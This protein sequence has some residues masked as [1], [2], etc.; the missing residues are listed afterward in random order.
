MLLFL[1]FLPKFSKLSMGVFFMDLKQLRYFFTIA[2]EGQITRAAKVLH[3]AQPPLSQSLKN[4]EEELGV[5]LFERSGRK[6][7]LTDAGK[8][9][10]KHIEGLFD[11]LD[12]ILQEVQETEK[13]IRGKLAIGSTKTLFSYLP[14]RMKRFKELYPDITFELREG[15][16]YFLSE[17]LKSRAI[18][19]ALVRLPLNLEGFTYKMLPKEKYMAAFPGSWAEKINQSS[20]SIFELATYPLMLLHRISGVGQ[21]EVILGGFERRGLKPN[22]ICECPDVDMLLGLVAEEV[23]VTIIPEKTLLKFGNNKIKML[24][25]EDATIISESA[26]IWLKDR[27]LSKSAQQFIELFS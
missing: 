25:I 15:D 19:L 22:I 24:E 27:Y 20:I 3:M 9:L 10:Y 5:K 23:G 4:L 12:D 6:L 7:I 1:I 26:I 16:S 21:Y 11:Q 13:G 17:Q 2:N 18:D 14:Q 8:V